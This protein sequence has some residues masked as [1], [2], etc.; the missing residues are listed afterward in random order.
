MP[1]FMASRGC[2]VTA[3]TSRIP[4]CDGARETAT[5]RVDVEFV[6]GDI[7]ELEPSQSLHLSS[8]VACFIPSG[9]SVRRYKNGGRPTDARRYFHLI[10][11][12]VSAR[13]TVSLDCLC[14]VRRDRCVNFV[15]GM[16]LKMVTGFT[17]DELREIFY[18]PSFRFQSMDLI[19]G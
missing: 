17:A 7:F 1:V 18:D 13:P 16:L 19:C 12:H 11:H 8:T 15:S 10:C 4:P 3:V 5:A 9:L 6:E 2:E 14:W